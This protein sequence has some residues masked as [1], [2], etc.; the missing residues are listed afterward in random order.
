M[1]STESRDVI[2]GVVTLFSLFGVNYFLYEISNGKYFMSVNLILGIV[3]IACRRASSLRTQHVA[4][5]EKKYPNESI[6]K[7]ALG[8]FSYYYN[9][10]I[11]SQ[12]Q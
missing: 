3:L 5:N 8:N 4:R 9:Y 11:N 1:T 6:S 7:I 2:Q 12:M 10:R